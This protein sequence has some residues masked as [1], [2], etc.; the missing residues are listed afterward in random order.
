MSLKLPSTLR[1]VEELPEWIGRIADSEDWSAATR[2]S[3]RE[4]FCGRLHVTSVSTDGEYV[5]A[6]PRGSAHITTTVASA[7]SNLVHDIERQAHLKEN[8]GR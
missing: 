1:G 6:S 3:M 4:A 7:L 5:Y 2:E 8:E